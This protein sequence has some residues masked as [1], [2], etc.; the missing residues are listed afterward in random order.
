MRG[1]YGQSYRHYLAAKGVKT[2]Y[3]KKFPELVK[4]FPRENPRITS[5]YARFRQRSPLD[6]VHGSFRTKK[7]GDVLLVLGKDKK[8]GKYGLQSVLIPRKEYFVKKYDPMRP[9]DVTKP[10]EGKQ[11]TAERKWDGTRVE[12][13]DEGDTLRLVNRRQND[14][15]MQFPELMDQG[16]VVKGK[17]VLDGELIVPE[18]DGESFSLLAKRE[19]LKDKQR[20]SE[21]AK[22]HPARIEVFDVLQMEGKDVTAESL[23]MRRKLLQKLVLPGNSSVMKVAVSSDTKGYAAGLKATGAEGVVFKDRESPYVHGRSKAWQKLKFKKVND[24]VVTG[25]E[26]GMGKRKGLIGSLRVSAGGK[27]RGKIGT[28]F[29][30]EENRRLKRLLDAGKHPVIRV[31]YRDVASRGAYREPVYLG[32]RSDITKR[33][34]HA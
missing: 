13:I 23:D 19:H 10:P 16:D 33:Q 28:G 4:D 2:R 32:L 1:W 12:I 5:E 17:S 11:W 14:K 9:V 8:T 3:R 6:F 29:T 26:P 24:V 25:Y 15:S 34:T 31:Q 30:D 22:Q 21:M 18:G 7:E 20:I 27:S